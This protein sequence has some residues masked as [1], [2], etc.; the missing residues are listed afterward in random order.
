MTAAKSVTATFAKSIPVSAE[1]T[2]TVKGGGTVKGTN[3][4]VCTAAAGKSLT[5][6]HD[7]A[8]GTKVTLNATPAKDQV[9]TGW[10]GACTGTKAVCSLTISAAA[11]V[12][13][14]FAK[15]IIAASHKPTVAKV[16]GG[17]RVHLDYQAGVTGTLKLNV[18][19]SGK[20][21]LTQ[22]KQVAAGKGSLVVPL[23]HKGR[24]V[25]TLTL[26]AKSGTQ[27]IHWVVVV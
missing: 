10:K 12:S 21:V 8:I 17:Y 18:T 1:L 11:A 3:G 20:H 7:Y 13:A 27:S 19:R 24:Y 23:K 15:P 25:F 14:T 26:T 2:L 16:S 5:C 6:T 4:V 9:F 22:T